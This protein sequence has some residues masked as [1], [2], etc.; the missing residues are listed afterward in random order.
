MGEGNQIQM[1]LLAN[2]MIFPLVMLSPSQKKSM[3]GEQAGFAVA[4][5]VS[6]QGKVV[7]QLG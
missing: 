5:G 2:L 3:E 4:L 6:Y 1:C 7:G